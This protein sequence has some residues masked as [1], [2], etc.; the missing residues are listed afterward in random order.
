MPADLHRLLV[1]CCT[2]RW[3]GNEQWLH[4]FFVIFSIAKNSHRNELH[5]LLDVAMNEDHNP[6]HKDQAHEIWLP[7]AIWL[8]ICLE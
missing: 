1:D 7:F 5:W 2:P 4:V 6:F 8:S 3:H